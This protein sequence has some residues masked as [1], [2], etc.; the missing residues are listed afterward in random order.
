L[1]GDLAAEQLVELDLVGG[2]QRLGVREVHLE[3]DG[4]TS[5]WSFSFAKPIARC[6]SAAASMNVRSGSPGSEW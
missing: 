3:L 2:D 1:R 5:G 6:A 4:A